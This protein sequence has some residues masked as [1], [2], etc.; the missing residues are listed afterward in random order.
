MS[1]SENFLRYFLEKRTKYEKKILFKTQ[2]FQS[3][4]EILNIN[5]PKT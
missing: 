3:V 1:A 5:F 4:L 2:F